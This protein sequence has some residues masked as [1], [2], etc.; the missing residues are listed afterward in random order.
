MSSSSATSWRAI[1]SWP[2]ARASSTTSPTSSVIS[3]SSSVTSA[4]RRLRSSRVQVLA[5]AQR[6]DVGPQR[7]ERRAE[8]VRGVRDQPPLRRFGALERGHHLVEAGGEPAELVVAADVDPVGQVVRAG[9]LLGG[10]RDL[11]GRRERGARHNR[12]E[13]GGERDATGADR[14]QDD[15]QRVERVIRVLEGAGHLD[16][17]AVGERLG[18]HPQVRALRMTSLN[19]RRPPLAAS[20][21][22]ALETGMRVLRVRIGDDCR[23]PVRSA[24]RARAG[25]PGA[26]GG[27]ACCRKTRSPL[28]APLPCLPC[29]LA[30]PGAAHPCRGR[31][32]LPQPGEPGRV[33]PR[34]LGDD[35]GLVAAGRCR[36]RR[37]A[38]RERGCRRGRTPAARRRRPRAPRAGRAGGAGSLGARALR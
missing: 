29:R 27:T 21:R 18:E 20:W 13:G 15:D 37:A 4:T 8:L 10:V 38:G 32:S 17:S 35:V 28:C 22:S 12:A 11:P 5:P 2:G 14:G 36:C 25:A 19:W 30:G 33:L 26:G 16:R 23:R 24:A 7:G 31:R 1:A 6:L 3:S 34:P 9:D